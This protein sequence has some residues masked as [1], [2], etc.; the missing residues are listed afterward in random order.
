[1]GHDVE[2]GE[3]FGFLG[4]NGAGKTTTIRMLLGLVGIDDGDAWL[5]GSEVPCPERL[6]AVG[7]MVEEPAFYPW[8]TG[9]RN[10]E[11]L[12]AE[13]PPVP[14]GAVGDAL[15]LTGMAMAARRKV[16]TY[17][18]GMRQRLGLAAAVLRRP[19]VVLLDE[20]ANGLDPAGIHQLRELLRHLAAGGSAVFLSSH[21][22][23]EVE[24]VCDRV[25][26]VDRGRLVT[27]GAV[28]SLAG[29][30]E[31]VEV[32]VAEPE[33]A[34]ARS[35]LSSWTVTSA[36]PGTLQVTGVGGRQVNQALS[37]A[38]IFADAI[39]GRR[40]SLEEWFLAHTEGD[41]ATAAS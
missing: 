5:L 6:A 28:A 16:R 7:A 27:T 24:Q 9:W 41:H 18:Q 25:A 36:A 23:S 3:I 22:L 38:G 1:M 33:M 13:G 30:S 12:A 19:Q 31:R 4:P 15:E 17:S 2:A 14:A 26:V 20:P 34:A 37:A 11:V 21:L 32:R 10:L 35:A 8:M 39:T 29:A 40:L